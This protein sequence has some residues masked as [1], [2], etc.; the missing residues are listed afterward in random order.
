MLNSAEC[1]VS[2]LDKSNLI[3]LLQKLMTCGDFHCFCLANQSF[4]SKLSYSL[5]DKAG[6]KIRAQTQLS[7]DSSFISVDP[8]LYF[9]S[10]FQLGSKD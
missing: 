9:R 10:Q 4:K 3:N 2:K 5:K 1:E 7:M 6:F 8:E